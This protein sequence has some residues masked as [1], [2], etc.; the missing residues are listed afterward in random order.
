MIL[1]RGVPFVCAVVY[2]ARAVVAADGA[3]SSLAR[4]VGILSSLPNTVCSR[5][6]AKVCIGIVGAVL[7]AIYIH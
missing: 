1:R 4:S 3:V 2:H 6:F 5:S 7:L